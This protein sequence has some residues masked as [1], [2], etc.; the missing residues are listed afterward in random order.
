MV[1][2]C[3]SRPAPTIS[4]MVPPAA[5]RGD[6]VLDVAVEVEAPVAALAADARLAGAA[7][8][9]LE[10]ADE[11]A[12]DPDGARDQACGDPVGALS[13]SG[14]DRRGEPEP[15]VVGQPYGLVLGIEGLQ[16]QDGA[17]DLLL[18]DL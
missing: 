3:A 4:P 9:R 16:H 5:G 8:R 13:I 2:T 6:G 12:V 17:E 11:E 7:E 10:V 14:G 18:H 1:V 15:R